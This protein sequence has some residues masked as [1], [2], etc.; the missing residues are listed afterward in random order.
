MAAAWVAVWLA[1]AVCDAGFAARFLDR[2]CEREVVTRFYED[3]TLRERRQVVRKDGRVVPDGIF[4][5]WDRAAAG[6]RA[7]S[8]AAA[9]TAGCSP[10]TPTARDAAPRTSRAAS[11]TASP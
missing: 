5:R 9:W 2:I 8:P 3:G 1:L 10:G 6:G 11:R 4:Q 7:T